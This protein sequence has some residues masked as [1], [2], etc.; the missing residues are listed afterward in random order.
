MRKKCK[1]KRLYIYKLT[2]LAA[3]LLS[4]LLLPTAA[5]EE[6]ALDEL[7]AEQLEA[8]GAQELWENLPT[9]TKALLDSLGISEF[10]ADLFSNLT[11]Q[12]VSSS[13][14]SLLVEQVGAPLRTMGILLGVVLLYA[15]M[16]GMRET[17]KEEALSRIFGVICA[18]AACTALLVPL[19]GCIGRVRD[20][21]E[22]TSV[23]MFSFVPV[24]SGI[25]LT[26]GQPLGAASYQTVVLFVAELI[27]LA[28]T[29]L[30]VPLM[31]TALALGLV[32]SVSPGMKLDAAGGAINKACSWLL[33]LAATLFV[34]LLSLQGLV[35]AA[36]DSLAGRAI[37]FSLSSFVPVVGGALSEAFSS[38]QGCLQ[39][40]KSTLGGFGILATAL[41]ALPP[42]LECALW[43]LTLSLCSMAADIFSLGSLSSLFK[44][45]QGV[46]K[47]L[48]GVL[49]ACS[50]FMIIATTIVTMAGSAAGGA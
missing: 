49:A 19:S 28:A 5:E 38:V 42:L 33:G 37:R 40:L 29:H 24:Y 22:S 6:S 2:L 13:L 20:A 43:S 9:Q 44:A 35:G 46:L 10:N 4:L 30:I 15:L 12:G 17:V 18:I 11:P 26:S 41:I 8:S 50:L 48:M 25:M 47:T 1:G 31:T 23:F 3:A 34:G 45:A 39:L 7:Y 14:F 32:G 36:A 21:A 16:D 27:S